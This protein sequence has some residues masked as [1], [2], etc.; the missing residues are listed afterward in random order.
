MQ[1]IRQTPLTHHA[2][3]H[4]LAPPLPSSILGRLRG[5]V[6]GRSWCGRVCG[7]LPEQTIIGG[8]LEV[9]DQGIVGDKGA[10]ASPFGGKRHLQHP[11]MQHHARRL[12]TSQEKVENSIRLHA[13]NKI[14]RHVVQCF[15]VSCSVVQCVAVCCSVLQSGHME[16]PILIEI[17][18]HIAQCRKTHTVYM[19]FYVYMY[20][21]IY[22]YVYIYVCIRTHTVYIYTCMYTNMFVLHVFLFVV[23]AYIHVCM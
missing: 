14:A 19:S 7:G 2:R 3:P 15:A 9:F 11:C 22:I 6:R 17:V 18:C 5:R 1:P 13:Y 16:L 21:Y 12:Q 20:T 23:C 4:S 8:V 10:W